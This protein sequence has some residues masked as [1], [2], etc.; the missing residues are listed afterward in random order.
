[1]AND[2]LGFEKEVSLAV[3]VRDFDE[4]IRWYESVLGFK[5]MYRVDEAG[6]CELETHI[7]GVNV[8]LSLVERPEPSESTIPTWTVTDIDKTR[9]ALESHNVRFDGP[10]REVPDMVKY[11]SFY[12]PDGNAWQ[13]AQTIASS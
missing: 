13:L 11:A 2:A 5:L 6:W 12:D 7:P 1:M 9:A 3:S 10:T 8:G 4:S